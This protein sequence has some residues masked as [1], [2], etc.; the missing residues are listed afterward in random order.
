M[1]TYM[2]SEVIDMFTVTSLD[3]EE[4]RQKQEK[5]IQGCSDERRCQKNTQTVSLSL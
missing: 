2:V 3:P 4:L 5:L 1:M